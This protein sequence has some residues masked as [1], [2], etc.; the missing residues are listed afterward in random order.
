MCRRAFH[1][2]FYFCP[3]V[4]SVCTKCQTVLVKPAVACLERPVVQSAYI[5]ICFFLIHAQQ[6]C[7]FTLHVHKN[8]FVRWDGRQIVCG[9]CG[10]VDRAVS[11]QQTV[12]GLSLGW[13][14]PVSPPQ[15]KNMTFRLIGNSN[16][17]LWGPVMELEPA[18]GVSHPSHSGCWMWVPVTLKGMSGW[19]RQNS[20]AMA[21]C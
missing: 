3:A 2:F 16:L 19:E 15:N 12:A 5:W 21:N 17:F 7:V 11:S 8:N 14:S 18:H 9:S 10:L 13:G 1:L 20:T 4:G 6:K